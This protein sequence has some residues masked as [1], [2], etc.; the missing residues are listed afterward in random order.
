MVFLR[1]NKI[2]WLLLVKWNIGL[3]FYGFYMVMYSGVDVINGLWL[4]V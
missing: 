4:L 3:K 2:L 1:W